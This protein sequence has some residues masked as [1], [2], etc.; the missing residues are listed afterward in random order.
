MRTPNFFK[1]NE[2][3][4]CV[5]LRDRGKNKGYWYDIGCTQRM[6]FI[7]C[8]KPKLKIASECTPSQPS[9][10]HHTIA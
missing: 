4:D 6:A 2:D 1:N 5:V 8:E 7:I 3:E 9:F 10:L